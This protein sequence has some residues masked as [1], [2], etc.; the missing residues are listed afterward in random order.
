M[1]TLEKKLTLHRSALDTQHLHSPPGEI[2]S[3]RRSASRISRQWRTLQQQLIAHQDLIALL[4]LSLF[5]NFWGITR[6][7]PNIEDWDPDSIAP[8]GPLV[9]AKRLLFGETWWEE[10]PPLHYMI[11]AVI[12]APYIGFLWLTGGIHAPQDAYPYGLTD[13]ETALSMLILTARS[14]NALMGVGL[15]G[16]AY[17]IG[18]EVFDRRTGFLSGLLFACN[19]I[20]VYYAHTGNLEVSYL[21]WSAL[22]LLNLA[23]LVRTP[24]LKHFVWLGVFTAFAIGTKDQAYGLFTLVPLALAV[25]CLQ[26]QK[27]GRLGAL[28]TRGLYSLAGFSVAYVFASNILWNWSGWVEHLRYI[29]G[30]AADRYQTYPNTFTGHFSLAFHTLMHLANA[31]N[32]P[33]FLSCLPG[34]WYTIKNR[35]AFISL[36]IPFLSYY[37]TFLSVVLYVYPRFVFPLVFL[38]LPFAG[39]ALS[40]LWETKSKFAQFFVA[41]L[42][43][44]SFAYGFLLDLQFTLDSRYEAE[45]WMKQNFTKTTTVG[46][47]AQAAYLPR[48]PKTVKLAKISFSNGHLNVEGERPEY[49]VLSRAQYRRYRISHLSEPEQKLVALIGNNN[50]YKVVA[51]FDNTLDNEPFFA[52]RFLP[53]VSPTIIILRQVSPSETNASSL[54]EPTDIG[55]ENLE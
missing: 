11:L 13:P 9:Y 41:A 28:V 30:P 8:L 53:Y 7:L 3:I 37:L 14:V 45:A 46:T 27:Q 12:S 18:K 26:E 36:V 17:K 5:L 6:G 44:H 23:F 35:Q 38:V 32:V 39:R 2:M 52:P 40:E 34:I 29:T 15:A 42:L 33:V 47:D 20:A 16:I 22:A 55:H 54:S 10:Y 49:L 48:F 43:V 50:G 1:S 4:C 25:F 24:A 51:A 21:F 31:L 19:P